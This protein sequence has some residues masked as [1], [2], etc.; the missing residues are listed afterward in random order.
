M[1]INPLEFIVLGLVFKSSIRFCVSFGIWYKV[2]IQ[3]HSFTCWYVVFPMPF[4][5]KTVLFPLTGFGTLIE[6]IWSCVQAFISL[7]ILFLVSMSVFMPVPYCLGYSS[8]VTSFEI[9]KYETSNFALFQ[10]PL[11]FHVNFRMDFPFSG[12]K[13]PLRFW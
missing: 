13:M 7:S 1:G 4:V 11:R 8:F 12:K 6:I 2:R 3:H 10:G 5:E 9:R